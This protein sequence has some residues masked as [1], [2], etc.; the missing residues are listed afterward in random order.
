MKLSSFEAS[1]SRSINRE[2]QTIDARE[3]TIDLNRNEKTR[4]QWNFELHRLGK[5]TGA[6][7]PVNYLDARIIVGELSNAC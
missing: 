4:I 7:W 1:D 2:A 3:R 5:M 6:M